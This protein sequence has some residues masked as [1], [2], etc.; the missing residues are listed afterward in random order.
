MS[1][2]ENAGG[3]QVGSLQKNRM[4]LVWVES[5]N[6]KIKL[7]HFLLPALFNTDNQ[8]IEPNSG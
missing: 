6:V 2:R 7:L 4:G 1:G 5:G 3:V 8:Q